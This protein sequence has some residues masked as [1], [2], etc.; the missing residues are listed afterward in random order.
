MMGVFTLGVTFDTSAMTYSR[1]TLCS[2]IHT[3]KHMC[4]LGMLD[5]KLSI[6]SQQA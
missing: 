4:G 6:A 1:D 5:K 2:L 3:R